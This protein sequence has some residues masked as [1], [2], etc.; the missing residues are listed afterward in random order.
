MSLI[1][2]LKFGEV[3]NLSDARFAAGQQA[4]YIGF[5]FDVENEFYVEE[6]K[7]KEIIGWLEG[8][9]IVAEFGY[10]SFEEVMHY[11]KTFGLKYVQL[12]ATDNSFSHSQLKNKAKIIQ[13]IDL[14]DYRKPE[15]IKFFIEESYKSVTYFMLSL[16]DE[17]EYEEYF[18][19]WENEKFV[20]EIC[21]D[22]NVILNFP[23]EAD[24]A[25]SIVK[26]FKPYAVNIYPGGE[27]EPG[28]KDFNDLIEL[29]EEL[30]D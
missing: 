25:R 19:D 1:T 29:V 26:K 7:A 28:M 6:D 9:E 14:M 15:E 10:Q 24:N 12:N 21:N 17:E 2:Q 5:S 23:F 22:L 11:I 18:D 8:P 30:Q 27:E 13:N 4:D 20:K 16:Y 3:D